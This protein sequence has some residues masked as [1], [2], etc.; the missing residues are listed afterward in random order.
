MLEGPDEDK[1]GE[2]DET[3]DRSVVIGK[4]EGER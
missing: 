1:V 3:E 4:Y 2:S